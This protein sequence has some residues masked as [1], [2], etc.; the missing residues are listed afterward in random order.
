MHYRS[1]HHQYNTQM[2]HLVEKDNWAQNYLIVS[3]LHYARVCKENYDHVLQRGI[4]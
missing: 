2:N 3:Q 1:L 4:F